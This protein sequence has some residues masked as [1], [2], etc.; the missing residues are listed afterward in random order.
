MSDNLK[1][2]VQ[3]ELEGYFEEEIDLTDLVRSV[4]VSSNLEGQYGTLE[5]FADHVSDEIVDNLIENIDLEQISSMIASKIAERVLTFR[6][7]PNLDPVGEGRVRIGGSF[8]CDKCYRTHGTWEG[9][10]RTEPDSSILK[11][12]KTI[13]IVDEI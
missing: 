9:N 6:A 13:L 5:E 7:V 2:F 1:R 12:G 11:N 8:L 3:N 10:G 4:I